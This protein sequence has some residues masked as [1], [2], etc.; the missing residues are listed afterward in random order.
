M[1]TQLYSILIFVFFFTACSP[2][3]TYFTKSLYEQEKW[4]EEDIMRIQFFISEDI[5]LS[6]YLSEGETSISEGKIIIVE[7]RKVQQVVIEAFT[8]GVLVFMPETDRFAISFEEG[9]NDAYLMFG[10]NLKYEERFALLAQDWAEE[11]GTVHYKGQPYEVDVNSA[12]AA[13][14]VDLKHGED[15]YETRNV[16][17]RTIK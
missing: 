16:Q 8:P 5:V 13:L 11:S 17:G 3:Y 12:F 1:K 9:D 2:Q 4:S 7:G 15:Q 6:R 10:P 14:M